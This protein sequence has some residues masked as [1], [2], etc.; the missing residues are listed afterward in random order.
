[1]KASG[2]THPV[3]LWAFGVALA[4]AGRRTEAEQVLAEAVGRARAGGQPALTVQLERHLAMVR[5]GWPPP[6]RVSPDPGRA[7]VAAARP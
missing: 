7:P 3:L 4:S 1:V 6:P 2:G 5:Q